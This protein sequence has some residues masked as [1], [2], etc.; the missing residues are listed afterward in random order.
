MHILG[1]TL[2]SEEEYLSGLVTTKETFFL[3]RSEIDPYSSDL[4]FEFKQKSVRSW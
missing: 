4:N 2:L 1:E 3:L